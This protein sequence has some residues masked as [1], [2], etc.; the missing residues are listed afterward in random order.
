VAGATHARVI[1][2]VPAVDPTTQLATVVAAGAPPDALAGD[3]V[4]A[5]ITVAHVPGIVV[6]ST[7][8]VQDP[9]TGATVVFVRD[10]HPKSGDPAFRMQR[11]A[12][13]ATGATMTSIASG[14]RAGDRVAAE[15]GYALLAPTGS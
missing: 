13:R 14:L 7:A 3:A 6:P 11:V 5:T 1:A 15:G 8:I 4:T 10:P 9:Q 2:V 12:V